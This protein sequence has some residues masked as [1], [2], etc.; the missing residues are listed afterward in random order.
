MSSDTPT[1][2]P[3]PKPF[4]ISLSTS[5]KPSAS[6]SASASPSS[7]PATQTPS[8][9]SPL[10]LP[11]RPRP[12][13]TTTFA[14]DHDSDDDE[15]NQQPV[16]EE[17]TAFDRDAGGAI[18]AHKRK[19]DAK[20]PLVIK[21]ESK[22]NWQERPWQ[23]RG[24][25]RRGLDL[26]PKEVRAQKEAEEKGVGVDASTVEVEGPSMKFGLSLAEK[27]GDVDMVDVGGGDGRGDVEGSKGKEAE[28][29]AP[30]KPLTQDE[31]AMQ[32]LIRESKVDGEEGARRS[33]L[34]IQG[35]KRKE[36]DADA[37]ADEYGEAEEEGFDEAKSFRADVA[38]RPDSASLAEYSAIPVEEFGAALLR[39]MG[40]KDGEPIGR[41]KYGDATA[42]VG[43]TG[44]KGRMPERRSG[45]LGIGAKELPGKDKKGSGGSETELGAW[46]KSDMR[47]AKKPGEGL[48]TPVLMR[49]KK[50][51]EMITQQEFEEIR[52]EGGK[53]EDKGEESWKER[54]D[55]N[56]LK[57][58]RGRERDYENESEG[59]ESR[60]R[61]GDR[62]RRKRYDDRDEVTS[63][64]GKDDR[65][66]RDRERDRRDRDRDRERGSDRDRERK[67]KSSGRPYDDDAYRSSHHSSS[68][69]SRRDRE[70]DSDRDSRRD[71]DRDRDRP[72]TQDR[73]DRYDD[74]DRKRRSRRE[75]VY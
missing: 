9:A 44:L 46:G 4:S 19:E 66:Y 58:G 16:T 8:T 39:G 35:N 42:K 64:S 2:N 18:S 50:T 72:S 10:P 48:Y 65:Y 7:T 43:P 40:W 3:K 31:I 14:D 61:D 69:S 12:R 51:G 23:R 75:E 52:K 56:L 24:A 17:V 74:D 71:R 1:Q 67:Y 70:R 27:K 63:D 25:K 57:N 73:K 49:N 54:R 33:D 45:Y 55:R 29:E 15:S 38:S 20:Q 13:T 5:K 60:R 53:K 6:A 36:R 68:A 26:L 28:E 62:D 59:Y 30:K 21:V 47:K 37:D 41:G 22:N 32:A 11:N 34:V